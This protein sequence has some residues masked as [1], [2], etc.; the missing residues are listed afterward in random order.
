VQQGQYGDAKGVRATDIEARAIFPA[1][2]KDV[3][4]ERCSTRLR[5]AGKA[6]PLSVTRAAAASS[7]D[8]NARKKCRPHKNVVIGSTRMA[9][10]AAT[11]G[12]RNRRLL[13]DRALEMRFAN[14]IFHFAGDAVSV[15][16]T[17]KEC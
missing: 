11:F 5:L 16:A 4:G 15:A 9:S 3:V 13:K 8:E 1:A 17:G 10:G 6:N 7:R 14:R 2:I 12:L